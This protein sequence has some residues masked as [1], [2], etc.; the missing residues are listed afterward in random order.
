MK[1]LHLPSLCAQIPE[2]WD[3]HV[4]AELNGQHMRLARI[5][6]PFVWHSHP[7][8]DEAFVVIKG[9][10]TMEF[11]THQVELNLLDAI[12]VPRGVEHR[13]VAEHEAWIL[14]FEPAQT[15]N[16]GD[17]DHELTRDNLKNL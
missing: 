15:R 1:V 8:E 14:L 3:P 2:T 17:T 13:P 12:V 5:H 9:S 10:F 11:R 16:T 7:N 4:I 6:G